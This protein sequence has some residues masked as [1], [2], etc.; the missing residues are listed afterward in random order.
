MKLNTPNILKSVSIN[1]YIVGQ[2]DSSA[3]IYLYLPLY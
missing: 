3:L 1:Q 2:I